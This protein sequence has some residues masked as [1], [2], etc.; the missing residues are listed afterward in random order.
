MCKEFHFQCCLSAPLFW[1]FHFALL[2][3]SLRHFHIFLILFRSAFNSSNFLLLLP[4]AF[5]CNHLCSYSL[6]L[7]LFPRPTLPSLV[8]LST[9]SFWGGVCRTIFCLLQRW[10]TPFEVFLYS[11]IVLCT[12]SSSLLVFLSYR[13]TYHFLSSAVRGDLHKSL[14]PGRSSIWS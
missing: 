6:P 5:Y 14:S 9:S 13:K 7:L 12:P 3:P 11:L 2:F 4:C 8:Q 10:A 1:D